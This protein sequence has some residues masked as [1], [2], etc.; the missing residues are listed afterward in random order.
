[1]LL[2][3][4]HIVADEWS[5]NVLHRELGELYAAGRLGRPATLPELPIQ[6]ADFA[7]WQREW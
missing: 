6:Y 3:L 7:L 1:L 2:T 5:L 4:H